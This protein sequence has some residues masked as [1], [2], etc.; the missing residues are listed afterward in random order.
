[1]W[2]AG[3]LWG[4]SLLAVHVLSIGARAGDCKDTLPTTGC[5]VP[6][7]QVF[8]DLM[9][10]YMCSRDIKA[11]VL[12][13]MKDGVIVFERGYG[14]KDEAQTTPHR[15]DAL[16]R[17]ASVTKPFTAAAIRVL[18]QDGKLSL[19]TKA[20]N[21]GQP[22][23]GVLDLEPFP[24]LGDARLADITIEHLLTHRGG[25]NRSLVGD[26]TYMEI[27]I[28]NA[29][30][31]PS[32]P[33]RENTVRYILGQ[34]LQ[35]TPGQVSAYSN[36][37][38][39]VL[40]LIVEKVSGQEL[41]QFIH[42]RVLSPIGV[43][44]TEFERG[45]TFPEDQSPREPWYDN[46]GQFGVN[47][48]DP[49]G[50]F[51]PTPYGVYDHE[52]RVGQGAAITTTRTILRYLNARYISG[53][54]I[55]LP[56]PETV[57]WGWRWNHTGSLYGVNALARQRGDGVNYAIIFNHRPASGD[58]S[59]NMIGFMDNILDNTTI[60]WPTRTPCDDGDVNCDGVVSVTDIG[61]FVVALTEPQTFSTH[62]PGC[63]LERAD[64]NHDGVVSEADIAGLVSRIIGD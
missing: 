7:L 8:D 44:R 27:P 54:N 42:D 36:I 32:P 18:I 55:G 23:G 30:G 60:N 53:D 64:M 26:L 2:K 37:G 20:F 38:Y 58:H 21:L 41:V 59:A 16:M 61:P 43:P 39:L 25:W 46:S 12:A 63:F 47:V 9:I 48:F 15:Q 17:V 19:D 22:G 34:P 45:R 57:P 13:I 28:A 11:G 1:M 40:G 49:N 24:S 10:S 4:L 35:H 33:G 14:W 51:V 3:A 29:M 52:A 31:I 6:E 50:P 5:P 62:Y 56:R